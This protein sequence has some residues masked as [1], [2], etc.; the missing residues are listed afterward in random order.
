MILQLNIWSLITAYYSE[1]EEIMNNQVIGRKR[2][3]PPYRYDIVGSFLRPEEIRLARRQ[4]EKK[5]ISKEE[6]KEVEDIEIAKLVKKQ[7]KIGLRAV[8]DGEF[9][10]GWWHLDFFFGNQ[11]N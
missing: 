9:R 4:Y 6:L 3:I 11:R 2:D 1:K 10:R 7:K 8:T 5:E